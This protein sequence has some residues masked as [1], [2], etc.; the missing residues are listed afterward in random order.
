ML[1]AKQEHFSQLVA[2]GDNQTAAYREAYPRSTESKDAT[3]W[4][5]A[6]VLAHDHKVATRI[7]ELRK[8][9]ADRCLWSRLDSVRKLRNIALDDEAKPSDRISAIREL[10][11]LCG[12]RAPEQHEIAIEGRVLVRIIFG[13]D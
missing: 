9:L 8:G 13:D 6:S 4:E 7:A 5:C 11:R 12:Y 1:I 2:S 10:N 3:V